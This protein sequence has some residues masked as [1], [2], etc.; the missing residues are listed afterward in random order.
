M[1]AVKIST[2]VTSTVKLTVKMIGSIIPIAMILMAA[3]EAGAEVEAEAEAVVEEEDEAE[4]EAVVE[5]DLEIGTKTTA[6]ALIIEEATIMVI[7][8]TMNR[9]TEAADGRKHLG[10]TVVTTIKKSRRNLEKYTFHQNYP[11]TKIRYLETGLQWAVIS[12]ST[13]TLK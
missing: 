2:A 4:A 1:Q 10:K 13:I 9:T 8:T 7:T 3:V 5:E 12:T 6:V 11:R